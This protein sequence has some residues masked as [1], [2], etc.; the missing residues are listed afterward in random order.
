AEGSGAPRGAAPAR[1]GAGRPPSAAPGREDRVYDPRREARR[2]LS[3]VAL[4]DD[5]TPDELDPDV[6]KS[7]LTLSRE[8]A[9]LVARHLVMTGRLLDEDPER[10]LVHARAAGALAG[11]VAV[12]R[13]AAGLAAYTAGEWA[14]ALSELRAYRRMSGSPEHLPVLADCERALGR[15]ERALTALDDPDVAK[16]E[17]ATRVELVIVVAGARRDLDQPD[18]AVLLLQGPARATTA[19]R[20]W[21]ARLWYAYADALLNAGREDEART[22]FEK[23]ADVD[24]DGET[25]AADRLLALDGLLFEDDEDDDELVE[26]VDA[27]EVDGGD[28]GPLD[29]GELAAGVPVL[30]ESPDGAREE[31][32]ADTS[33]EGDGS[34]APEPAPEEPVRAQPSAV[35]PFS[36][37]LEET[38][39]A[40]RPA[41]VP[42]VAFVAAEPEDD[43]Q[44]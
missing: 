33:D 1:S 29:L 17:Q 36:D 21:A 40:A 38:P 10:A 14:E 3:R 30:V 9:D 41:A 39:V 25:D 42:G 2:Q 7:L 43:E 44:D 11:R 8:T 27:S 23:A 34:S 16:L 32:V 26:D 24:T 20:P 4:P 22:W 35:S 31:A 28:E 6:R 5:V 19:R 13:E 37:R 15:P 18:A 12:V